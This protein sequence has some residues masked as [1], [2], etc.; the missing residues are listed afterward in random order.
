MESR[1]VAKK[2][3]KQMDH[4]RVYILSISIYPLV[5]KT[6]KTFCL[7]FRKWHLTL[8]KTLL[9]DHLSFFLALWHSFRDL[10]PVF[11]LHEIVSVK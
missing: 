5:N 3:A 11:F 10:S 7:V 6:D 9:A 4:E 2:I 8:R 1:Y